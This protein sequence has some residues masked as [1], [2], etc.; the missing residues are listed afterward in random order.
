M[1]IRLFSHKSKPASGRAD[2]EERRLLVHRKVLVSENS[3]DAHE[4][5]MTI[6]IPF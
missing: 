5:I 6:N 4:S 3:I 2:C 1:N